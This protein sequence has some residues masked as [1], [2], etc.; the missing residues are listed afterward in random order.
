MFFVAENESV[1]ADGQPLLAVR[2]KG[3][4]G[5]VFLV[6]LST[7]ENL[8]VNLVL[9]LLTGGGLLWKAFGLISLFFT[10]SVI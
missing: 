5:L 2:L 7:A 4:P 3:T 9:P 10:T 6:L 1:L 8:F